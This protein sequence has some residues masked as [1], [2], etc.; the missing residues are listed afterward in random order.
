MFHFRLIE[1]SWSEQLEL[2]GNLLT[3]YA[4]LTLIPEHQTMIECILAV[5]NLEYT[6]VYNI[7]CRQL[8]INQITQVSYAVVLAHNTPSWPLTSCYPTI[9]K[10]VS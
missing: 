1:M 6:A 2:G 9:V 8:L 10:L 5:C 7:P 3:L 4:W